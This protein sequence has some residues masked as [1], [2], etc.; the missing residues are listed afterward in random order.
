MGCTRGYVSPNPNSPL[1]LAPQTK[2]LSLESIKTENEPPIEILL[3]LL[4][5]KFLKDVK[6]GLR[7]SPNIPVPQI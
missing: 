1:E 7:I 5:S 2:T 6:V 3:N 4:F